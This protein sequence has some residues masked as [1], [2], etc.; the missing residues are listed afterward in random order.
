MTI[1]LT[2]ELTAYTHIY[3]TVGILMLSATFVNARQ[4]RG[5]T[6]SAN[7]LSITQLS[8]CILHK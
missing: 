1:F 8:T 2:I 7:L 4:I 5:L 3:L 6:C